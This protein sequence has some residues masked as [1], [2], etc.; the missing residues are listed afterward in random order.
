MISRTT[1][2]LLRAETDR[3]SL[4]IK[5]LARRLADMELAHVQLAAMRRFLDLD[6]DQGGRNEH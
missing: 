4:R 5:E 2:P 3:V 1:C 6:Q